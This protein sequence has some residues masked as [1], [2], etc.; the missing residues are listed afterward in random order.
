MHQSSLLALI[1]AAGTVTSAFAAHS[2]PPESVQNANHIFN[3]IHSS[4]R[5]WG[6]SLNHNG[7][8]FF[9]A[10][11]PKGTKLYHGDAHLDHITGVRWMAFDPEH[12]FEF[13]RSEPK[14]PETPPKLS[15]SQ[16]VMGEDPDRQAGEDDGGWLHT[17]TTA[18]DLRLVYID[19]MSAGKSKVGTLDLQDRVLFEDKIRGGVLQE[20]ARA[21]AVCRIA[22]EEWDGRVD[23]VIRMA[24]GFE[25]ILCNSEQNLEPVHVAK[26]RSF[27][28][29]RKGGNEKK[30]GKP[31]EVLQVVRARYNGIGGDRVLLNSDHFVTAYNHSVDLFPD[32]IKA[33]RLDHLPFAELEP[34]RKS[35]TSLVMTHDVEERQVNWQAVTDMIVQKYGH[36]LRSLASGHHH[37]FGLPSLVADVARIWNTFIDQDRRDLDQETERCAT[38]FIPT[39]AANDSLAHR[40]AYTV[41]KR[42]CASLVE[43]LEADEYDAAI[44]TLRSLVDYLNWTVWKECHGCHDDEFC[45]IPIWPQG[46]WDDFEHPHCRKIELAYQGNNDFWGPVW[47]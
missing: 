37:H 44:S 18:R 15:G 22:A 4:M 12:A 10:E 23:G 13:A 25:V 21:K 41:T 35:L 38:Q 26:V 29:P 47:R 27:S 24:S 43:V 45:Q 3:A 1:T 31:V 19:G 7:M 8:S 6:S 9:L 2:P 28:G 32:N 33:P 36:P 14:R 42:I 40:A 34:I 11:M 17:Y 39:N 46:S 16:Q 30:G 20:N 5:Q